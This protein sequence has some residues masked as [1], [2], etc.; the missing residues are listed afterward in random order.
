MMDRDP[1]TF[2][3]RGQP[4]GYPPVYFPNATDYAGAQTIQLAAGQIFQA[5]I[6]LVRRAYYSI[7]VPVAN[8][9]AGPGIAVIVSVQGHRGPGFALGYNNRDQMIEGLL[10]NGNYTL[11]ASGFGPNAT[12]GL[13]N[14]S[15]KG[16]AVE[17]P[18][19]TLLPNGFVAVIVLAACVR[20]S[21]TQSK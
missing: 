8:A 4:Y 16:A 21:W 12:S 6:S 17:S 20:Q 9:P 19:M 10:P 15:V 14:I 1:V 13:S 18:R 7:K 11:E 3:P 5:D 2:D